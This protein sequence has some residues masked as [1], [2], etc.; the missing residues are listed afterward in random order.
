MKE[1]YQLWLDAKEEERRAESVRID[2]EKRIL[3]GLRDIPEEGSKTIHD[4]GFK[5]IV[6]QKI[7]RKLDADA[8][9]VIG[10]EIP[11]DLSPV[12][13]VMTLRIDDAGCRWLKEHRPE[14]WQKAAVAITEKPAKPGFKIEAENV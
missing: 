5:V 3:A 6:T 11:A 2:A 1:L 12:Q 10:H 14:L 8:W 4:D 13:S 7:T 9:K